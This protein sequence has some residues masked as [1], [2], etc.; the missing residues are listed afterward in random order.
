MS[1]RSTSG[2]GR[3]RRCA[4]VGG[5]ELCAA[6][7]LS[8]VGE[9]LQQ[10]ARSWGFTLVDREGS[11][12]ADVALLRAAF[13]CSGP[14]VF[15]SCDA[16]FAA[17]AAELVEVGGRGAATCDG[18][19]VKPAKGVCLVPS[20]KPSRKLVAEAFPDRSE[21]PR[22]SVKAVQKEWRELLFEMGAHKSPVR[23]SKVGIEAPEQLRAQSVELGLGR[24]LSMVVASV[25][26]ADIRGK[27]G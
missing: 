20:R 6:G 18:K 17:A 25:P 23:L 8:A 24:K 9:K 1:T 21:S 27:G 7:R 10:R 14:V 4:G 11:Q 2:V 16:V 26:G 19:K 13:S 3:S 15:I 5:R 12:R 22:G